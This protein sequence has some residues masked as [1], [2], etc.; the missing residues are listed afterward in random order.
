MMLLSRL[1]ACLG[2]RWEAPAPPAPPQRGI[3]VRA[4]GD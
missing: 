1:L 4:I 2:L 3:P